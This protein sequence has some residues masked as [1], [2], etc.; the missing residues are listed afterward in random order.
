MSTDFDIA[1]REL[2]KHSKRKAP[3]DYF[4]FC[5]MT[6]TQAGAV[7]DEL[8]RGSTH[9]HELVRELLDEA[10]SYGEYVLTK[11]DMEALANAT[12]YELPDGVWGD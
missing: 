7:V 1:Y 11:N 9:L 4:D 3:E 2:K 8:K 10:I 12:G 5:S 6:V